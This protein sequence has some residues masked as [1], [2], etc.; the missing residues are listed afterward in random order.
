MHEEVFMG[1]IW[2]ISFEKPANGTLLSQNT[3]GSF[4]REG[5]GF[6]RFEIVG[7]V[8]LCLNTAMSRILNQI[9]SGNMI[10]RS[11]RRRPRRLVARSLHL[12]NSL[13]WREKS[14]FAV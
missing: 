1:L 10:S 2:W 6:A 5:T 12:R 9:R 11:E 13:S 8:M 14:R 4:Q 3:Q 7:L